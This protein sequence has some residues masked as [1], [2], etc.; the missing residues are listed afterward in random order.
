MTF[1]SELPIDRV[2]TLDTPQV[3]ST[4]FEINPE[5]LVQIQDKLLSSKDPS[6]IKIHFE[7]SLEEEDGLKKITQEKS[8]TRE[9]VMTV[10]SIFTCRSA[11]TLRVDKFISRFL[12]VIA[13][14]ENKVVEMN[15]ADEVQESIIQ[16]DF[17][18]SA[19]CD[20]NDGNPYIKY[21]EIY[22][23]EVVQGT[24]SDHLP[25]TFNIIGKILLK[26]L[27]LTCSRFVLEYN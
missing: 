15:T 8:L 22:S 4:L 3:S 6:S 26:G 12:K 11:T 23:P 18:L 21:F 17:I 25:L 7:M 1:L 19:V 20:H 13:G 24:T 10:Y 14:D 5:V 16:N 27:R 2:K 9:Q